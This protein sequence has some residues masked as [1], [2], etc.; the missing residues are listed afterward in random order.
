MY[1]HLF[2]LK[3]TFSFLFF[4]EHL[5]TQTQISM[6]KAMPKIKPKV[7]TTCL[8]VADSGTKVEGPTWMSASA[9]TVL[10]K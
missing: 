10:M 8:K 1:V 4:Y 7:I 2:L 6:H 3:V 5:I 9:F